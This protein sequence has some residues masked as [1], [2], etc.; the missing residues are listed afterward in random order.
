MAFTTTPYV[1]KAKAAVNNLQ[2]SDPK[3]IRRLIK[4]QLQQINMKDGVKSNISHTA[5]NVYLN[6]KHYKAGTGETH[7]TAVFDLTEY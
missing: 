1:A 2:P 5:A 3:Y 4:V 6:E 7:V